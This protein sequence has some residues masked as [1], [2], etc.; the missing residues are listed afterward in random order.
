MRM[1]NFSAG[2][3]GLPFEVLQK[4]QSE[5]VNYH[6]EGYSIMEISHRS[7]TYEEVHFGAMQKIRELYNISDDFDILFLQG[8]AHLQFSMIPLNLYQGGVAE[9]VDTGV[10][11]S[12]AI[13]EAQ[14]LGINHK[15]VASSKDDNFN[16]IP[17]INFDD[18]A[19]FS[20]ICSN[21]TIY[22]TQYKSLPKSKAPLVVD[23]SSD[24]FSRPLDF[25]DIGVLYGGAQKNAG[26]SGVTIV[27]I[28]KDLVDRVSSNNVPMFLRYK[29]HADAKSLYNTPPTFAIYLLNLNMQWLID[30]GGLKATDQINTKKAEILYN[31]IDNSDDFYKGHAKKEDRSVMNVSFNIK[32][33]DLEPIFVSEALKNNMLG[34][35]GH[36]HLGGIRASIY[37]AVSVEDVSILADFMKEFARKNG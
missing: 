14:I 25:S 1:I 20:Y 6:N 3:T 4:A 26:P 12:K 22:G 34:L 2:P 13:K 7:K 16:H 36:R 28:R 17:D 30:R 27:I 29:T 19:D 23:S 37:N 21:N 11:T 5:F 18:N 15:V 8:G 35:K 32:N 31:I 24:F 10:W 9:Y 33:K